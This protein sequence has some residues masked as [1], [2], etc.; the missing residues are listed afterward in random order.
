MTE[1]S[2]DAYAGRSAWSASHNLQAS[3]ILKRSVGCNFGEA[4]EILYSLVSPTNP[5]HASPRGSGRL[6]VIALPSPAGVLEHCLMKGQ[7][8]AEQ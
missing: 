8:R 7:L 5:R 6:G 4:V 1:G 2:A 3:D